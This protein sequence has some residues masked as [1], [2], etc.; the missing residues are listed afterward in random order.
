MKAK[1]YGGAR[2]AAVLALCAGAMAG[3]SAQGQS[4]GNGQAQG[5]ARQAG[6]A[7]NSARAAGQGGNAQANPPPVV[8]LIPAEVVAVDNNMK[9]G[10]WARVYDRDNFK[11]DT[12]TVSGPMSIADMAGP[13]GLKW[14]DRVRSIET[15]PKA[16][17]TVFDNRNFRDQVAQFKPAQKIA[18][19][20]K[21]MGFFD[22]FGSIRIDCAKS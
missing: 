18:D 5:G 1:R 14:D 8:I 19:L 3:A 11:G 6:A 10:C 4:A 7:A 15:G 16:T 21:R 22:E 13:F 12:L 17:V 9:N 20:S 2:L